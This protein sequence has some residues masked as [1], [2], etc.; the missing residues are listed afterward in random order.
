VKDKRKGRPSDRAKT[1]N[2][3]KKKIWSGSREVMRIIEYAI[4]ARNAPPTVPE[5]IG[6]K[7]NEFRKEVPPEKG[8]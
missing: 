2:D 5:R 4:E 7:V 1:A 6:S 3:T 8:F